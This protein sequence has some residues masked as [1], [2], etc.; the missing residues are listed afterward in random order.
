MDKNAKISIAGG[1]VGVKRSSF[2]VIERTVTGACLNVSGKDQNR[3]GS[4]LD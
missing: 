4:G 2:F 3:E 1:G